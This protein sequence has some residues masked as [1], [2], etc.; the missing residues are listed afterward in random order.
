MNLNC[1]RRFM[2]CCTIFRCVQVVVRRVPIPSTVTVAATNWSARSDTSTAGIY[3]ASPRAL[4]PRGRRHPGRLA[5]RHYR[6]PGTFATAVF[7]GRNPIRHVLSARSASHLVNGAGHFRA[8]LLRCPKIANA[9]MLM[10]TAADGLRC[11][12]KEPLGVVHDVA[13]S[14]EVSLAPS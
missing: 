5:C 13:V 3:M 14:P 4:L 10:L 8:A 11:S 9:T 1:F 7:A 12:L 2:G 6:S